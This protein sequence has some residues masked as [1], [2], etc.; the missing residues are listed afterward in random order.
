M[1]TLGQWAAK[2]QRHSKQAPAEFN[3]TLRL[4]ML[5]T[6]AVAREKIGH[7]QSRIGTF[8][9]W[10]P[11]A[12]RT[13][14]DKQRLGY[15][16]NAEHNPLLRTGDMRDSIT[17]AAIG[18]VGMIGATDP[19]MLWHEIGTRSMPPRPVIGPAMLEMR[20]VTEIALAETII[21]VMM[22]GKGPAVRATLR[23]GKRNV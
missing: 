8:N 11:L 18:L 16:F 6:A 9:A 2:L 12:A 14:E 22:D 4:A 19:K 5:E 17:G 1:L 10:P 21:N 3:K 20:P 23:R 7:L 15:D 13:V